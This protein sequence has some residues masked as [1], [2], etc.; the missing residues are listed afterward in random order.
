M[1]TDSIFTGTLRQASTGFGN[2]KP[3]AKGGSFLNSGGPFI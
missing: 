1:G 3:V 2:G